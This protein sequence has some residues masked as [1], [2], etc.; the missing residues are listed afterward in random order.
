MLLAKLEP[1]FVKNLLNRFAIS[2]LVE[3]SLSP[4]FIW[5]GYMI[6]GHCLRITVFNIGQYI[7]I[8]ILDFCQNDSDILFKLSE[9]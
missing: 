1:M 2:L 3:M 4:H 5:I 7:P 8:H 9:S 6:D